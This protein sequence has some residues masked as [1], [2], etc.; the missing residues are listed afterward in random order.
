MAN[1][2]LRLYGEQIYPNISNYLTKYFSPEIKKDDFISMYKGGLIDLKQISLKE[3]IN[4]HPQI[5]IE[6]IF[7][8]FLN[9][10]IPNEK[11]NFGISLHDMKCTVIVSEIN[12]NEVEQLLI[13]DKK[14]IIEDFINY[15]VKKI[16]KK[17]GASF[18]DNLIKSVFEKIID[19]LVID[20]QNLE[21]KIKANNRNNIYFSF[22][23]DKFYYSFD[24]GFEMKNI[25]LIYHEAPIKINIIENFDIRIEIKG[26]EEK[27]IPNQI[28]MI[29]YD[30]ILKI[31]QKILLELLNIYDIFGEAKYKKI[32]IK[33]KK[34]IFFYKPK[35]K[36]NGKKDY[37]FLWIYAIRTIIKLKKYIRYHKY[38]IF[39][40]PNFLQI[41]IIENYLENNNIDNILLTEE[42]NMLKATKRKVEKK[43][44]DNKNSNIFANAFSFF[45]GAKKEEKKNEL[46]EDEKQII[47]DIYEDS[48]IMKYLNNEI[49]KKSN[50]DIIYE[51]IKS[52][53]SNFSFNFT[54]P[55]FQ[56]D[57]K[58]KI[59]KYDLSLF[60]NSLI[61]NFTLTNEQ[62]ELKF[63]IGDIGYKNG[64]S[65]FN[66]KSSNNSIE[67]FKDKNNF[68]SLN[69][70]F[71]SII[72][73]VHEFLGILIFLESIKTIKIQKI[74]QNNPKHIKVNNQEDIRNTIVNI[75][76]HFSFLN[77]FRVNKIP[78]LAILYDNNRI[79]LK[80]NYSIYEDSIIIGF[81]IS[82]SFGKILND[83]PISLIRKDKNFICKIETPI[84][85]ILKN[86]TLFAI[87]IYYFEYKKAIIYENNQKMKLEEL[88][89]KF[90][91]L[92]NFNFPINKGIDFRKIDLNEYIFNVFIKKFDLKIYREKIKLIISF[93]MDD[94][95]LTY[96]KNKLD[97]IYNSLILDI[98]LESNLFSFL[99]NEENSMIEKGKDVNNKIN[100]QI[101]YKKIYIMDELIERIH[102]RGKTNNIILNSAK[103]LM[104]I[105]LNNINIF[106]NKENEIEFS[107]GI[108][109]CNI[110]FPNI[111]N[112]INNLI[113]KTEEKL[114]IIYGK[115]EKIIKT[116]IDTILFKAEP[117]ILKEFYDIFSVLIQKKNNNAI[118]I[119]KESYKFYLYIVKF[120]Y[121]LGDGYNLVLSK[122]NIS[123]NRSIK[124][125]FPNL[126]FHI[127]ELTVNNTIHSKILYFDKITIN[128]IFYTHGEKKL[129]IICIKIC[130]NISL[131]NISFFYNLLSI[132]KIYNKNNSAETEKKRKNLLF[133]FDEK[134]MK[135]NVEI[136]DRENDL[137]N[138]KSFLPSK[139]EGKLLNINLNLQNIDLNFCKN[140]SYEKICL[141]LMKNLN[142]NC[143]II[144]SK[145][146]SLSNNKSQYVSIENLDLFYFYEE[147]EKFNILTKRKQ[148]NNE[149]QID[150]IFGNNNLEINVNNNEI[151]LRID[152]FLRLYY[153]FK[154]RDSI[155]ISSISIHKAIGINNN[156]KLIFNNSKFQL[157][158]SF[159]GKENLFLDINKFLI[160]Y[161]N[162]NSEFPYGNYEMSIKRL[163]SNITLKNK[164]RQL[165]KTGN[166][167]MEAKLNYFEELISA[168]II[169]GD[170]IVNLSYMDFVSFLRAYQINMKLINL[171]MKNKGN[172]DSKK[173]ENKI[174]NIL[175]I[176]ETPNY[177][178][179]DNIGVIAGELFFKNINIILIDD[180][181]GS[182][183]PFLKFDF[184]QFFIN[185]NPDYSSISN[186]SFRMSSYNY[187]SCVWEP[188]I[189]KL[190]LKSKSS[191][192]NQYN[193]YL[194]IDRLLID[195]SD[196]AISFT[197]IT[198]NNWLTKLE[199]KTK[200]FENKEI[201][202]N[203]KYNKKTSGEVKNI[204]KITN[205]QI[206][207]YTGIELKI[208]YNDKEIICPPLEKVE[209]DN[210]NIN[211]VEDL[212]KTK[213][214]KLIY[215]KEHQYKIPL[216][217]IIV[218]KHKIDEKIFIISE[219]SLSENKT[220]NISLYS[221][222]IFKNK[223]QFHLKIEISNQKFGQF[224]ITLNPNSICG[225][226]LNLLISNTYFCFL[227]QESNYYNKS[228]RTDYFSLDDM[229]N[230]QSGYKKKIDFMNRALTMKLHKKFGSL[231]RISIYSE[232]NIVNCLPCEISIEYFNK[233]YS[234]EKCFQHYITESYC[235][236]LFIEFSI[237]TEFGLFKTE[238]INLFDL[239]D[240]NSNFLLLFKNNKLS[241]KFQLPCV[242]KNL[243]G[244][245]IL[246]IYSE[247]ILYNKSGLNL[248]I[249][250][251]DS[252]NIICFGVKE[253]INLIT[254]NIDYNEEGLQFRSSNCF[255]KN[256]K[257]YKMIEITN[258]LNIK[259]NDV[260][261][262]NPFDIII[263]K[264]SSYIKVLNNPNFKESIIS[265]VFTILPMCK[266]FNLLSTKNFLVCDYENFEKRNSFYILSPFESINFQF[267]NKGMKALLGITTLNLNSN[268][269]TSLIKFIFD[270]GIYTLTT[271]N[272]V[273]NLD[274]KKNPSSGCLN[275]YIVENNIK[276]SQTILENLSDEPIT[277]YQK[278]YEKYIQIL[279][280]NDIAP[281]KIYDFFNK[282]FI[283]ETLNS[284]NEI[285]IGTII[286]C[287]KGIALN[288]KSMALF[289]DNG[290]KLKITF[291]SIEK[292]NKVKIDEVYI[293]YKM[294]IKTIYIS[295]IGDNEFKHPK[296]TKY[297][298]NELLLFYI[299]NF[300]V[301]SEIKNTAGILKN[302]LIKTKLIF[303]KLRIY[304]QLS[305]EGKFACIL[306][307]FENP[308][309]YLENE[310]HFYT[311]QNILIFEKQKIY[312][313]KLKLG[314]DPDFWRILLTFYDN[315]LY[316]MD[317]TYFNISKIFLK[318]YERDP[319]KL[320]NKYMK[321]QLLIN[322]IGLSYPELEIEYELAEKGLKNLLK[323]RFACSDF[324]IW[325]S[326]GLVGSTQNLSIKDCSW[327]FKNGTIVQYCIWL[328][329]EYLT[330]IQDKISNVGFKG[331][332]GQFKRF[333]TLDLIND[334]ENNKNF[335]KDRI[336]ET[337][338]F[339]DK[340][341]Y[342]K[343]YDD[344]DAILIKNIQLKY[345]NGILSKYYPTKIIKEKKSFYYFTTITM[346]HIDSSSY[347][348][349]WN[350]DYFS[351]KKAEAL[352]NKVKVVYNQKIDNYDSCTFK[353]EKDNI[354]KEVAESLN[355]ESIKNRE[356]ILEV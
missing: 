29:L 16:E 42:L 205:N 275:V 339:Y 189:E 257:I 259:M 154:E 139:C 249:N 296:L 263:K 188:V 136:I 20:I 125:N 230:T 167:F 102:L 187:I 45:F 191:Y 117:L 299:T 126:E 40:L 153:L 195:L 155:E 294:Y 26:S 166:N 243:E 93:L 206:I 119:K 268:K 311:E 79:D 123:N 308:C 224:E 344:I 286:N 48:N 133:E 101:E 340:F 192:N 209:L 222:F 54:L 219:N 246:I 231:R 200:K 241:K 186:C 49:E 204:T 70:G 349:M 244:E 302:N 51:K 307:N 288:S 168:N 182:Y 323:E 13:E 248:S 343:E 72:I 86:E 202:L 351:I 213:Y 330:K 91:Q 348:L 97:F 174:I 190:L 273:F 21:L 112:N 169:L 173:E 264:K 320:I 149:K 120:D 271:D 164:T 303:D 223:T 350:V 22:E 141:L 56:L 333:I 143:N 353:C 24:K 114:V 283:F 227:I 59:E 291:H 295:I 285:N 19:G 23:I 147:D 131:N 96:E 66:K 272:Y 62:F 53:L 262:N 278:Y 322:A 181:K 250:F 292:Y 179:N 208:F 113:I 67:I 148:N 63:I 55:N 5:K 160:I 138:S 103:F 145:E 210:A 184:E 319:K 301:N 95:K 88:S 176:N 18:L 106:E 233:K 146:I 94:I 237:N 247:L 298:R 116:E 334:D 304:N 151:N 134:Q 274:I 83:I 17:D 78:S 68:I 64:I 100:S 238:R 280:Q 170:I 309:A 135:N 325:V 234:I 347:K 161:N 197:L 281:L 215:D 14:K 28:N 4:I 165:F 242:F 15:S 277:I 43:I 75:I 316:R 156:L 226:P 221:P 10:N 162:M 109:S 30:N 256:I 132:K 276:N 85:I 239:N 98:N 218:L 2:N 287:V 80:M 321:G 245:K 265:M 130:S 124:D 11:E 127:N 255:S 9:I 317:L 324:Y 337:R 144:I 329:Y 260:Y 258:Y 84:E 235:D 104:S 251:S 105:Y 81:N 180:S 236:N 31:N 228:N 108:F 225:L 352:N 342:F 99:L 82:D 33:Y 3:I 261:D 171:V 163:S 39:E 71:E 12:D 122:I 335:Q 196:M 214:I 305:S 220:I 77:N 185:V 41:K 158:T 50:I 266:I 157:S 115:K 183:Q 61:I 279:Y 107:I 269:Y 129:N 314:I 44:I 229:S 118:E 310:L 282:E 203:N 293:N 284:R 137:K 175:N 194:E 47:E 6:E 177:N 346:F 217:K 65:F 313:K 92:F 1:I 315:V 73:K 326:K 289:Q 332:L 253:K 267:F 37:K 270:I 240:N 198:F 336:R 152:V 345:K 207:N 159:E 7:I 355:E 46:T 110:N 178:P 328:Y 90:F 201:I 318:Q 128:F 140:N 52:F 172:F 58:N 193:I 232:Y 38:D 338:P 74:F 211:E 290:I 27:E 76:S 150:I 32:Y 254:S 35:I 60:I 57:L 121:E 300:K 341:K 142:F 8:S 331:I 89:P 354:A 212:G 199:L 87:L 25:N 111:N 312:I 356:N 297:N 327:D 36:D 69:L 252:G 34:K 306:E 216:E